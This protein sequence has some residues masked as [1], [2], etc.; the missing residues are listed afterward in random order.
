MLIPIILSG[1]AGTRLWPV[2]REAH[3]KPFMRIGGGK[4]LLTQTHERA[5]AVAGNTAPLIVTNRD[6]YFLS[7]DELADQEVKPNY[8]LE[9][10]GRNTAPAVALAAM[11]AMQ[12][13]SDACMLVLPADHLIKDTPSFYT[14]V[15]H[16]EALARD[17]FLVLFGIKPNAPETGFGYI[18]MGDQ[19]SEHAQVVRRFVEK[20]DAV[21][22]GRYLAQGNY[23]WNSGM[24]CFKASAILDAF[25]A[26]N[27]ALLEAAADVWN[28][29]RPDGDKMELPTNFSTLENISIDYAVM[30]KAK[31]IAV[32]PGDFDWSDIGAWKAVAEAIPADEAGNTNNNCQT[33]VIDSRNT[34]IETKDRLVAVIGLDNLLVI[35]TPDALLVADKSKSQEVREVVSRLKASGHDAHKLHRTVARPWGTYTV[36]EEGAGFKIKRIAVKPGASLSLQMH[37]HRSEHWVVVSGTA[38]VI[39]G[40]Q[41]VTL[42][43]NQSTYIPAGN[44]H[45]LTNT[46]ETELALIEVQCGSYLGEDDIVRFED[47]YGRVQ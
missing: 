13:K 46:G 19:V 26:Y 12:Q 34:H 16:A 22:A 14:A 47:I 27:P 44:R 40:E 39:N 2:S 1:G 8:L 28:D 41:I 18:E 36:L 35:D 20:P 5:L 32:I 23:V 30:E 7:R 4:S 33:I 10:T 3:P 6:Y 43:A 38:E 31:N 42:Q 15:R 11:W 37:H 9:P 45:R 21:T 25:S 24:F 17:G 29:I